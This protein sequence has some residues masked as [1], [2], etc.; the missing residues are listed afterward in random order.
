MVTGARQIWIPRIAA[1]VWMMA[2]GVVSL[3][4]E[5]A[6]R[7]FPTSGAPSHI[8]AYGVLAWLFRMWP[9]G[10]APA[11]LGAWSYGV[12]IEVAQ[13]LAGWRAFEGQDLVANAAGVLLGLLLGP[14][15][16]RAE[17]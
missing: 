12:V 10:R 14:F 11:A 6:I 5:D 4:P 1:L 7:G 9:L 15:L 8:V 17:G 2:I 13:R 3:L 16:W